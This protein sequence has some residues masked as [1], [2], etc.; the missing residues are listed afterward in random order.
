[1]MD[2]HTPCHFL[3]QDR[4]A[5]N[6]RPLSWASKIFWNVEPWISPL[7]ATTRSEM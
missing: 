2:R 6:I 5:G 1:M 4:H 7:M 3:I